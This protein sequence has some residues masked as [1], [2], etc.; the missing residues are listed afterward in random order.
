MKG[1]KPPFRRAARLFRDLGALYSLFYR[2]RRRSG[3]RHLRAH[4]C[5]A[6]SS[7]SS[8]TGREPSYHGP[9]S[10]SA[11]AAQGTIKSCWSLHNP[12]C[13]KKRSLRG[14]FRAV[15]GPAYLTHGML[16]VFLVGLGLMG[17]IPRVAA[18]PASTTRPSSHRDAVSRGSTGATLSPTVAR[19]IR[20]QEA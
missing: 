10:S 8:A 18:G 9:E 7:R 14:K 3:L 17:S 5:D 11:A 16:R 6:A 4:R 2:G 15:I 19:T 13:S 20:K 1:P 12:P